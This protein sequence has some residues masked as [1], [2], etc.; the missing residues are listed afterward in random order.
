MMRTAAT[1]N[2]PFCGFHLHLANMAPIFF[3]ASDFSLAVCIYA[4]YFKTQ[5]NNNHMSLSWEPQLSHFPLV[6]LA[7]ILVF[8]NLGNFRMGRVQLPEFWELKSTH[9][10]CK[11]EKHC[12]ILH[13]PLRTLFIGSPWLMTISGTRYLVIGYCG[14]KLRHP[15]NWI[16]ITL[17]AA[18]VSNWITQSLCESFLL[19]G[20]FLL[21]TDKKNV[22]NHYHINT[23]QC[24]WS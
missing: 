7:T 17:F 15:H 9:L 1:N 24:N 10:G 11:V 2:S 8:M 13:W 22:A 14:F 18:I 21:E 23:G 16:S 3:L 6:S 4:W 20:H 19:N 5:Q 12:S